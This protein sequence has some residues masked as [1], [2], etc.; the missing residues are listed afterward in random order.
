MSRSRDDREV[1]I[2]ST[3]ADA[4][5]G[6]R[7]SSADVADPVE[8]IRRRAYDRYLARGG[9]PGS[10]V[11]DWYA[12]EREVREAREHG[13]RSPQ[14][15]T[16]TGSSSASGPDGESVSAPRG[17]RADELRSEPLGGPDATGA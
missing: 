3:A 17:H 12:A 4:M 6:E 8:E 16:T 10:E 7:S 1:P 2:P 14:T 15:G 11:D 9:A 5:P 13:M